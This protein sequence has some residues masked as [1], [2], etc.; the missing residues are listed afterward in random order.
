MKDSAIYVIPTVLSRGI[1]LILLPVYTHFLTPDVYGALELLTLLY[2]LL[3]L[4]LP[5]E[6]SQ[7]VARFLADS[8]ELGERQKIVST[9]YWF[10][11]GVFSIAAVIILLFP[12]TFSTWLL[13][14]EQFVME[15]QVAAVAMLLNA[16][17][18]VI[19]NQ[20]R[21]LNEAKYSAFVSIVFSLFSATTT[22]VCLAVLDMGLIG[23][24]YGQI[25]GSLVSLLLGIML[26][27]KRVAIGWSFDLQL[28]NKML[29]FSAPL[30]ISN[31]GVYVAT[32]MD[33]WLI[34][35]FLGLGEVGVY[36]VAMRI[37]TIVAL[38][39]AVFQMSLTPLIYSKYKHEDTPEKIDRILSLVLMTLIP[40]IGLLAII[41]PFLIES[42][43]GED[44]QTA[45]PLLGWLSLV[46]LLM[47]SYVFFPGMW[48]AG[49]TKDIALVNIAAASINFVAN[50]V[51]ISRFGIMGAV[52]G[53]MLAA[54][55]LIGLYFWRSSKAY[56]VPYRV[57]RYLST[58][59]MLAIFLVIL[60][61]LGN[62]WLEWI[63]LIILTVIVVL[64]LPH[65]RDRV[66]VKTYFDKV[67]KGK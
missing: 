50:W 43:I 4:T 24:I 53:S 65:S 30:V 6:I 55:V 17:Q 60:P 64:V 22:I 3:N 48:I 12:Q 13:G 32:Y 42:F 56:P 26:T 11:C 29:A 8:D 18:Y 44:Y 14:N 58:I 66:W 2:V 47:G 10:T 23:V 67:C 57:L 52:A 1:G 51:L 37:A 7:S 36:S 20:L 15:L 27:R 40:L 54:I 31:I 39:T 5:L 19:Q 62:I 34:N 46:I 28:L 25:V 35:V 61:Q 63:C 59:S 38:G 45:G 9:G 16:L 21:W 33:R 49:K 41:G